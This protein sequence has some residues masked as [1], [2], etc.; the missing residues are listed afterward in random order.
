MPFEPR[1]LRLDEPNEPA[2]PEAA[3]VE[4]VVDA[5]AAK[6]VAAESWLP[7]ELEALAE[8]LGEDSAHLLRQYPAAQFPAPRMAELASRMEEAA[9]LARDQRSSRRTLQRFATLAAGLLIAV[10]AGLWSVG[11]FGAVGDSQHAANEQTAETPR[12]MEVARVDA[13]AP[14]PKTVEAAK[15]APQVASAETENPNLANGAPVLDSD[16][17]MELDSVTQSAVADLVEDGQ[18]RQG[19]ISL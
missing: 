10:G 12:R 3:K 1:I 15:S 7:T 8:Q 13:L 17:F 14:G 4:A 18:L 9:A 5:N 19:T 2:Q 16:D 11:W 6:A